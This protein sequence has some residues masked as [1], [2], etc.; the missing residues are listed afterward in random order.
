MVVGLSGTFCFC[1]SVIVF[2]HLERKYYSPRCKG[3]CISPQI[4]SGPVNLGC[5]LI[6]LRTIHAENNLLQTLSAPLLAFKISPEK[7]PSCG[8]ICTPKQ[9]GQ[10]EIVSSQ[11]NTFNPRL[12]S[13]SSGI[14]KDPIVEAWEAPTARAE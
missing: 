9:A 12:K 6:A 1:K 4:F 11:L 2:L 7:S 13:I 5:N 14:G 3:D 10:F 8:E